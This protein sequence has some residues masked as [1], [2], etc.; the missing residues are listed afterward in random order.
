MCSPAAQVSAVAANPSDASLGVPSPDA[1]EDVSGLE[2]GSEAGRGGR[3]SSDGRARSAERDDNPVD[4]WLCFAA[5]ALVCMGLVMVYSTSGWLGHRGTA[6][7]WEYYLYRQ[8]AF[9]V[10]GLGLMAAVSRL[11]YRILR[12]FAPQ[13]MLLAL[14]GLVMVLVVGNEVNG[15]KRWIDFGPVHVQPSEVA[16][17]ALAIFLAA[18]LARKG[19]R[20]RSFKEGF[21]PVMIAAGL[22]ML[23]V[24][25]EK[26]L[27]TTIL[28][29]ALT[30]TMLFVAGT[31]A[32]YVAA[33][34]MVAVPLAWS[35]IVG[36]AFRNERLEEWAQGGGYQ[37]K[38]G[39]IAL[40]SGGF[41]GVGLGAGR[42]KLGH[43]PENHTDFILAGVGEELGLFGVLLVVLLF[44]MLVWRGLVISTQAEDR[45]GTYLAVGLSSL[46]G[47]QALVNMSVVLNVIPAKGITLPFLSYGG[48]SMLISCAAVGLLLSI[49]RS[50]EPWAI[51]DQRGRGSRL[52]N[53][54]GRGAR[55]RKNN[56]SEGPRPNRRA[57]SSDVH[58]T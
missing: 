47:L 28:L 43:L 3:R 29:G 58:A 14:A 51:S 48:S 38:Q 35:R 19:E 33:A 54:P 40:G 50:P 36:V 25:W 1:R 5:M 34:I 20:V 22:T 27:G 2:V 39:L 18:V 15:A 7:D 55:A 32:S 56:R 12:R 44:A 37:V 49:S 31:R 42:Q 30:L 8:G 52:N 16:K 46:F 41:W 4:P 24:H 45:F 13:L 23:L 17:V 57:T 10:A 6:G 26:D 21:V 9:V 53:N 11:D